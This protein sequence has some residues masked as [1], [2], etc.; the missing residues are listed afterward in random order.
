[1]GFSAGAGIILAL[2]LTTLH[3]AP[4]A[5]THTISGVAVVP[6]GGAGVAADDPG[7]HG[8]NGHDGA[9]GKNG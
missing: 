3:A 4:N 5:F 8:A 6:P 1:V 9:P 7:S 2:A